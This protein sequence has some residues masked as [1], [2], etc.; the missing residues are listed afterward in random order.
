MTCFFPLSIDSTQENR[1][2]RV[3]SEM[4]RV[5]WRYILKRSYL[6]WFVDQPFRFDLRLANARSRE[7]GSLEER[8]V[9]LQEASSTESTDSSV[10]YQTGSALTLWDIGTAKRNGKQNKDI[11]FL[12]WTWVFVC[13]RRARD[14]KIVTNFRLP[15]SVVRPRSKE[16]KF[17]RHF[18]DVF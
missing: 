1:F 3:E 11:N 15:G 18:F 7:L 5:N 2:G 10:D 13:T 9:D 6:A 4:F 17:V 16:A 12:P 14:R 8:Q